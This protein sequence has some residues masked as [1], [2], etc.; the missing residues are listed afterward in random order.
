MQIDYST[1]ASKLHQL[2]LLTTNANVAYTSPLSLLGEIRGFMEA[3]GRI[4][5]ED[6]R[7]A[8]KIKGSGIA[9]IERLVSLIEREKRRLPYEDER[10]PKFNSLINEL[11][12]LANLGYHEVGSDLE[13]SA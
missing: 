6:K 1:L 4:E 11:Y 13:R 7:I 10:Q 3:S 12:D 8:R 2:G 5:E 9:R